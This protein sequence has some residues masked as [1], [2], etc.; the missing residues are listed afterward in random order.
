[1]R[2][3]LHATFTEQMKYK[4]RFFLEYLRDKQVPKLMYKSRWKKKWELLSNL[5]NGKRTI[6]SSHSREIHWNNFLL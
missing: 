5:K 2:D 3:S 6:I 4:W 1:M